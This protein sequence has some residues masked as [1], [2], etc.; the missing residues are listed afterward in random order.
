MPHESIRLFS[1]SQAMKWSALPVAGGLYD[2]HPKLLDQWAY[3]FAR[4]AEERDRERRANEAKQKQK[5]STPAAVS[6]GRASRR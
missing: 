3:I 5:Q 4:Q 2:Q 6:R 1:L